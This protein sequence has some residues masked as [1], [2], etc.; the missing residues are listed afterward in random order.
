MESAAPETAP[1][2]PLYEQLAAKLQRL[3]EKGALRAG[4]RV[5]SVRAFSRQQR[6][7]IA[8]VLAAYR[9]LEDQG[10]IEARPQSGYYVRPQLF[11]APPVPEM[12]EPP[13]KATRVNVGELVME[14]QQATH[15]SR[16][17][18]LGLALPSAEM[19]PARQLIRAMAAIG[20]RGVQVAQA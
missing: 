5:P 3:I 19:L 4:E 6:V 16:L 18:N 14:V 12:Y 11:R 1:E 10:C 17:I 13:P 15:Y 20:R 7:S 8:T 2:A 9:R